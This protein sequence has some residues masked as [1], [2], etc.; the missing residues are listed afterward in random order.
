MTENERSVR[1]LVVD[2]E[3][4]LRFVLSRGLG[5]LGYQVELAE[6]FSEG[7]AALEAGGYDVAFFD[8]VMPDGSGLDLLT[9]TLELHDPPSVVVMTAEATMK[10]AVEAMRRGA[11]DYLTKPFDLKEV[12]SLVARIVEYRRQVR[13][14]RTGAQKTKPVAAGEI[15]GRSPAMQEVFKLIGRA[16]N[17]DATILVTGPTG[18]GKELVARALW[19]NSPRADAPFVT[20]NCAAIPG[21]L[22]ESELFGHMKGAFTGAHEDRKGKFAQ[23]HG[24]VILLDEV[25]DMP[26]SLQAKM[27][28]VLQEREVYPVGAVRSTK[29]DVR[30]VAA[31][32]RD[33]A[34]DVAEGRFRE[35]L[36][37]RLNVV[38]IQLPPLSRRKE[39]IPAL[40]EHFLEK[41]AA[42]FN[43]PR[44]S[45]TPEAME[46]LQN[47]PWPG[48][49]RELENAVRRAVLMAPGATIS[50]ENLPADPVAFPAGWGE[51][52]PLP[53]TLEQ[54]VVAAMAGIPDGDLHHRIVGRVERALIEEALRRTGGVQT[55]AATLLGVNR[56]TL[57]KKVA[58]M[59]L[60]EGV[61]SPEGR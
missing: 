40:V 52:A 37:H 51:G 56:N 16:A 46:A 17:S 54:A 50:R 44:K 20:V 61:P 3:P 2:D 29:I 19:S 59:G 10:N 60:R 26:L 18:A 22:L 41:I 45:V 28:R 32:N 14:S 12:E 57:M 48:N 11:F 33:L 21:Q 36:Y 38:P 24:G 25:G 7:M 6:R 27:L 34:A 49:V 8:I 47:Q 58:E 53:T 39:D 31:T 42:A 55:K 1:V 13:S 4:S 9:R 30:V 35:D 23:A 5:K 43:E 15:V